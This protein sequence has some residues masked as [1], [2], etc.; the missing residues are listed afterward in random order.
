MKNQENAP[1][2]RR[3]VYDV[4]G[5]KMTRKKVNLP[6]CSC[7]MGPLPKTSAKA[8]VC[9]NCGGA[10]LTLAEREYLKTLPKK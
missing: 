1:V 3:L 4:I 7:T 5:A 8:A 9:A 6:Q 10:I 2:F